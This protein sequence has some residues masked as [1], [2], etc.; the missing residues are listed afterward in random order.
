MARSIVSLVKDAYSLGTL[1][2]SNSAPLTAIAIN[3]YV[4][5]FFT[6]DVSVAAE[7]GPYGT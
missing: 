5:V 3:F 2:H 4:P 6:C 1:A 7:S